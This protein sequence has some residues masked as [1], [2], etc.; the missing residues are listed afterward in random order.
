VCDGEERQ[1]QAEIARVGPQAKLAARLRTQLVALT[2]QSKELDM[3]QVC[4]A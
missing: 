3:L 4:V 2:A 1:L